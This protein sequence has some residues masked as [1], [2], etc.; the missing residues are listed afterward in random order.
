M[1]EGIDTVIHL[2]ADASP[3][4]DFASSLLENNIK[5]TYTVF[6]AAKECGCRRVI[7][8][9]SAHVMSAYPPDV[10]IG[11][12]MPVRPGN[13]Y[14]VSKAFGENL[15][16]YFAYRERLSCVVV[17]IGAYTLDGNRAQFPMRELDAYLSADD[18]NQLLEKCVE[19]PDIGFAIVHA[20]SDN[21]FKRLDLT[22][23]RELIDYRPVADSFRDV[24]VDH[25]T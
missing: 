20:V 2:G 8:A 15:A 1:C 13:M 19:A 5:A 23:T 4:A 18:F 12:D 9:S 22:K 3:D 16:A 14:G 6:S 24:A 25:V 10:Q 7:F 17:R 21:R 11:V